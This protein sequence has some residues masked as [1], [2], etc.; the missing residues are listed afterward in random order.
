MRNVSSS[1]DVYRMPFSGIGTAAPTRVT[2]VVK[3]TVLVKRRKTAFFVNS[4]PYIRV[5]LKTLRGAIPRVCPFGILHR[6]R[7]LRLMRKPLWDQP[8]GR[9]RS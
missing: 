5:F 6:N 9:P 7:K 1:F 2:T 4:F 3:I 8:E